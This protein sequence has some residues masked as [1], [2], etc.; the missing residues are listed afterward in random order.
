MRAVGLR[1]QGSQ[2]VGS[3]FE[4]LSWRTFSR[5]MPN[6]F[7]YLK[8][9]KY[10]RIPLRNISAPWDRIFSLKNLMFSPLPIHKR[11]LLP[12]IFWNTAKKGSPTFF[13]V[14][15]DHKNSTEDCD[16]TPSLIKVFDTQ[17][18]WNTR[19]FV[20]DLLERCETKKFERK[21]WYYLHPPC[22]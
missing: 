9:V 15:R 22:L 1:Q 17:N 20:Y 19:G 11:F 16:I 8:L 2:A 14:L 18:Y 13:L 12:E 10:Q 5:F 7:G 6:I 4:S 21:L 3:G